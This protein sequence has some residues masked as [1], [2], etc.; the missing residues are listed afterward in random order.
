MPKICLF[1]ASG[2]LHRAFHALPLLTN[3]RGEPVNALYGYSRMITKVLKS[4]KP[5]FVA[6]C[7]DTAAATFRHEA[8]ETYKAQRKETDPALVFQLPMASELTAAWGLPMAMKDGF[9][10]DDVIATLALQAEKHGIDVLILSGDK[11]I[12]QLVSTKIHVRDEIKGVEYDPGKVEERYGFSPAHL[13]DYFCLLGD[14]VDN[15]KGVT[16]IGEVKARALIS[17]YGNLENIYANLDKLKPAMRAN[18]LADK[19]RAFQ[20][21]LMIRLRDDVPVSFSE[22]AYTIKKP[23]AATLPALLKR[24]EFRGELFGVETAVQDTMGEEN[25]SRVVRTVLTESD[26]SDLSEE[27]TSVRR[28]AYDLETDGLNPHRCGIVGISLALKPN[29]AYYI[30][31]G[32]RYLGAPTQLRWE[33]VRAAISK[34][35]L[36]TSV[37]K[38]GQNIKFDNAILRRHGISVDGPMIDCMLAAYCLDPGRNSFGLKDMAAQMLNE[39]MTRIDELIGPKAEKT[40]VSVSV[41]KAAPYAGAD[42]EVA[43]RLSDV[44]LKK[45]NEAHLML[46]FEKMEMPLVDVIEKMQSA[47]ILLDTAHLQSVGVRLTRERES[48]EKEIY[49]LAGETFVLNSPKQLSYVLF[50][51]LKLPVVKKTKT[52]FSTDEDVLTKL[53]NDHPIC[54]KI[55]TYRQLA[56]LNSTYV[57]A[58][59]ELADPETHRIHTSFNQTGTTTGRLSSTEP[60]LQNIPV[61]SEHG[62][63]IRR[64]FVAPQGS[65]LISADYSQIDLRALAHMSNDPLLIKTFTAGGDVHTSTAADVFHVPIAE[66][67]PEMRRRAK[68]INFGIVYGQQA[69]G[70]SQSLGISQK[71]AQEFIDKYFARYAGV[72]SW[73]ENTLVEARKTGVVTTLAGRRRF[74]PDINSKNGSLKGFAERVATNTPIQGSSADIIK[75]AM[76][77]VQRSLDTSHPKTLMLVQVHDELLFEVPESEVKTVLPLIVEGMEKAY[78][79]RVPL[80]VE[81]KSG[82]NWTDM[83]PVVRAELVA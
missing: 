72:K 65:V 82:P 33:N 40:F 55:I 73:I 18:L 32:H 15:V 27:L 7:F 19:E 23:D 6:I 60:N 53:A 71:E 41:E 62:R 77:R 29:E 28:L 31:V 66:V 26:L 3:S 44:L 50:E 80:L 35:F 69:Y 54:E 12:L 45:L 57:E 34:P 70:L 67:T 1:D 61:K 21:R 36:D 10:A 83:T 63:D 47:G 48:I 2:Y 76:I 59:L 37:T 43:L 16:G 8:T 51:K 5:D 78:A 81:V 24:L 9:E 46:L 75:A 17:E 74:V 39:R 52:G 4:E 38:I 42:A 56:K 20:N 25:T 22:D 79:L 14:S 49:T 11:D 64:A 58:L 30:P 13:V 68:A